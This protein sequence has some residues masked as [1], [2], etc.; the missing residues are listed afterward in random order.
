MVEAGLCDALA[1][2]YFYPAMLAA[3]D[4]LDREKR[5][6]RATLWSLL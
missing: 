2:Y 4:R 6:D 5:A 3:I 1:S